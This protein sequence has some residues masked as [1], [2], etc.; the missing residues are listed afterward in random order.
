VRTII[1][2]TS[3]FIFFLQVLRLVMLG[4]IASNLV[5]SL[6]LKLY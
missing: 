6:Y 1:M 4:V 5:N 2:I 3:F